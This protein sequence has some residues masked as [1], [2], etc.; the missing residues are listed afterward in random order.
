MAFYYKLCAVETTSFVFI[1]EI[2]LTPRPV[3]SA[4][5]RKDRGEQTKEDKR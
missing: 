3:K 2:F 4:D 5:K 1:L